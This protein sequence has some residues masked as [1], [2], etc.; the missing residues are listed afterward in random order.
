MSDLYKTLGIDR[1]SDKKEIR[2]AYRKLAK[3]HH[4]DHGG[5]R[6][7]FGQLTK[8]H[9]ILI[10]EERRSKY[11]STGDESETAPDNKWSSAVNIIATAMNTVL[12][13]LANKGQSPLE[14]DLVSLVKKKINDGVHEARKQIRIHSRMLDFEKKMAGRFLLSDKTKERNIFDDILQNRIQMLQSHIAKLNE[15]IEDSVAAV[16]MIEEISYK[17]DE[18]PYE[19]PDDAMMRRMSGFTTFSQSY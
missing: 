1:S 15:L 18:K 17:R 16:K 7:K 3:K 5:S 6:E 13:E 12:G 9:D 11:D 19:N 8:A 4:P 14:I 10:D 2:R